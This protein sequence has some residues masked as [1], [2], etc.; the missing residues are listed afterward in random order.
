MKQEGAE[1][2]TDRHAFQHRYIDFNHQDSLACSVIQ[3]TGAVEFEDG[4]PE[5]GPHYTWGSS[6][7]SAHT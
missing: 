6:R 7:G 2:R 4:W 1:E 3:T 5:E